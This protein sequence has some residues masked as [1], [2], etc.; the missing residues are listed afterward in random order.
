MIIKKR[1]LYLLTVMLSMIGL[2]ACIAANTLAD[3]TALVSEGTDTPTVITG[4]TDLNGSF[5]FP[6]AGEKVAVISPSS[7]PGWSQFEATMDGLREWGYEPVAGKYACVEERTLDDCQEDLTWAL[8]DPEIKAIYCIRGGYG[9]SEVMDRLAVSLIEQAN[10][11]IIGFSD[12]TVYHSAWIKANVASIHSSMSSVFTSLPEQCVEAQRRLMGGEVPS[13]RCEGSDYDIE[14]SAQ[15]VLIG[16]NLA[17]LT[18]VLDTAYDC[19]SIDE[20]YILFLEDVDEDYELIHRF[21]TILDHKGILDKAKGLIF[22]EWVEYPEECETYTGN[23]RGGEF[24]SV[25]D[26]ISRQFL[27]GKTIPVAF[28]FPAGHGNTNYPLL[29]GAEVK[30]DVSENSFSLEWLNQ[31][32]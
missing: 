8:E 21:L 22:G 7:L 20:P 2:S 14:G 6:E 4:Y 12:I 24:K 26:M 1:K 25:A 13:Y 27:K 32:E 28:G 15:G 11:P 5:R 18:S 29:M 10:K 31:T 30:L 16:G 23:S 3:T 9:S 17:T 19:T